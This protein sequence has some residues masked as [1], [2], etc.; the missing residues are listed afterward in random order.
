MTPPLTQLSRW[1]SEALLIPFSQLEVQADSPPD[2]RNQL[3]SRQDK[4]QLALAA[5]AKIITR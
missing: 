2:K 1:G 3:K 4:F 5:N